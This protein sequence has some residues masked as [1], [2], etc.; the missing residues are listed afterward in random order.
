[1]E[2]VNE[3]EETLISKVNNFLK[4]I[5]VKITTGWKFDK[6]E[7]KNK[8]ITNGSIQL[9]FHISNYSKSI[10]VIEDNFDKIRFSENYDENINSNKNE[11]CEFT[12]TNLLSIILDDIF[13]EKYDLMEM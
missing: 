11:L 9:V 5:D 10:Y 7:I 6:V 2:I 3:I 12:Y 13:S 8:N 1:M 4:D